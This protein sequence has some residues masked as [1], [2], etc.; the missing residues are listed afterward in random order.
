MVRCS[1]FVVAFLTAAWF[2]GSSYLNRAV[3]FNSAMVR[4]GHI[5]QQQPRNTTPS[6][7]YSTAMQRHIAYFSRLNQ[8]SLSSVEIEA[9]HH[10]M[11]LTGFKMTIKAE[12]IVGLSNTVDRLACVR[13][14][15]ATGLWNLVTGGLDEERWDL[16][17]SMAKRGTGGQLLVF[18]ETMDA[19]TKQSFEDAHEPR[20][21]MKESNG[22][23]LCTE[24]HPKRLNPHPMFPL[25]WNVI[26]DGSLSELFGPFAQ[27]FVDGGASLVPAWKFEDLRAFYN[28]SEKFFA[29]R[30]SGWR[31]SEISFHPQPAQPV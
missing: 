22:K 5:Q 29:R 6:R 18:R 10:R 1:V 17:R 14:P 30:E 2:G 21:L 11:G 25:S 15:V 4:L 28:D 23:Q 20:L 8:G 7:E 24:A 26:T 13:N 19:L 27:E 3:L 9:I 12:T 31:P 16:L